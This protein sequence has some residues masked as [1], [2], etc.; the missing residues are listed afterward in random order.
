M[1]LRF[2]DF[3]VTPN[4]WMCAFGD[5]PDDVTKD[6]ITE[7]IK[8][9][10]VIVDSDMP[11]ARDKIMSMMRPTDIVNVGYNIKGYDLM[12]A[13]GIYQGFTPQQIKIIN[14]IIIN[15]GCAWSTKEHIRMAPFAKKRISGITYLDLFDSSDGTL[16]EK[17]ATLELSIL[18]SSVPFDKEE[19]TDYDKEDMIFYCKHDVYAAMIWYLKIVQPFITSKLLVC[20]H[21]GIEER[22][23][24]IYT[25]AQL[26]GKALGAKRTEFSDAER[27]DMELHSKI[28]NYIYDNLP[29]AVVDKVLHQKESYELN[30]YNNIVTFA[31]G[32]IHSTYDLKIPKAIPQALYVESDDEWV[33]MNVD[34]SS[35]YPAIMIQL[36]TLS[37]SIKNRQLFV[38]VFNE[39]VA[40]KHKDNPTKD[41]QDRQLAYKLILNT[42]YGAGG[43][44]FLDLCDKYHRSKC[45][46]FGQLLL[47]ALAN[48]LYKN[49]NGLAVIQTNTD[50]ILVYCRRKD[51]DLVE[52]YKN[53]WSEITGIGMDTDIVDKIWQRDV[54][55]YLMIKKGGKIKRKGGWLIDDY[56]K[57]G[58]IKVSPLQAYVCGKA[59]IQ[60]LINGTDPLKYIVSCRTLSDF[61]ITCKKGPSFRGVVQRFEDGREQELFKCNRI[62]ATK[63]TSKGRLYKYKMF[64]GEIR[65]NQMP[66]TPEHCELINDD[67]STYDIN[68]V[69][70]NIDFLYYYERTIDLLDLTW[71]RLDGLNLSAT[72]EF[73]I[74]I[75]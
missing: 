12:I 46:R 60:Y 33:L 72:D 41:D 66:D 29:S 7:D 11:D 69:R 20:K 17:E 26:V 49:I 32:G 59:A 10:F 3:E 58:Y 9:T 14:D 42:T 71:R 6:T 34:A 50:G 55:N 54:N 57:P 30:L 35:Y 56:I 47:T 67:L 28:K 16:K 5:L 37:R 64:K 39:R 18:E 74:N 53:E 31:D 40:I 15:P 1:K 22:Y 27:I 23:G 2:F 36:D 21:F 65:Y 75:D 61:A 51:Q 62:Y 73:K 68:D 24:Y 43:C 44:E 19:L 45:C 70:K 38:D 63:D 13:N 25:N 8:N 48:K 52:K 4:W